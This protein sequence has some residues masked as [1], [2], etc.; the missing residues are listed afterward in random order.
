MIRFSPLHGRGLSSL[1]GLAIVVSVL[2]ASARAAAP[3]PASSY[4]VALDTLPRSDLFDAPVYY[5]RNLQRYLRKGDLELLRAGKVRV[6]HYEPVDVSDFAWR[7]GNTEYSWWMQTE[8]LRFLLPAISSPR[9]SDRAL[10]KQWLARWHDAHV[11]ARLNELQWGEPMTFA[12][13]AMVFVYYLKT[14]LQK[15]SP[16]PFVVQTLQTCIGIH[17]DHLQS[18]AHFDR[19]NNHGVIDA[20]GLLETTRAVPNARARALAFERLARMATILVSNAGVEME[21]AAAYHFI[22]LRWLDEIV[23]YTR[24][25]PGAPVDFIVRMSTVSDSMHDAAYFLHDHDG[26]IA[27][28]GD[29]DSVLVDAY[30]RNLRKAHSPDRERTLFDPRSGYAI[31]KGN[32]RRGDGRYVIFR[33]PQRIV[34]TA[35]AHG[36]AFAVFLGYDGEVILGDAGRFSYTPSATRSYFKSPAAHNTVLLPP[37]PLMAAQSLPVVV[38]ARDESTYDMTMWSADRKFGNLQAT[39][40]VQIPTGSDVVVDDAVI[41]ASTDTTAAPLRVTVQWH[42]GKDVRRVEATQSGE[43]G[44]W[45]WK[46][47]TRRGQRLRL[48]MEIRGDLSSLQPELTMVRGQEQPILGWY[49]PRHGVKRGVPLIRLT[50]TPRDGASVQTRIR[51]PRR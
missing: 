36:D 5:E 8:E 14:E 44:T 16:D 37:R 50:F 45:E 27:P 4:T 26:W 25:L 43:N 49:S 29:T 6:Q 17:Q 2:P 48:Q 12:Y 20:L 3:P 51:T 19:D 1:L 23:A 47:T 30:S 32:Q 10:A 22:Y 13:R 34:M 33:Q 42:L 18:E 24:D 11:V 40:V 21:H 31:Y 38:R 7:Q 41:D 15:R 35:H 39:R 28:I 9:E 46:L